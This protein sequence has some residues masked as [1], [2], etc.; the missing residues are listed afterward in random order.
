[1]STDPHAELLAWAY[2]SRVVEGPSRALQSLLEA[3]WNA[4]DIA[5]GVHTRDPAVGGLIRETAARHRECHPEADLEAA[6]A[7]GARLIH[8]GHPDWPAAELDAAFGFAG[9]QAGGRADAVAPHALW[10]RGGSPAALC[11]Q[12][13]ALVGTRAI[14]RYGAEVTGSLAR[15]L[16]GHRW[17]VVS[18][19]ALGVDAVA[20]TACL[21]AG[22]STVVVAAC[23]I[24]VDYPR[25]HAR[26]F[27]RVTE[28][29]A[30]VSEYPP[31]ATPHRHRFLTRNRLVAALSLGTVVTEA[32]WRSGALNTLSWA[33][34][35]GRVCMAVPGPVTTAG[36]VGCHERIRT[37]TAE[38]VTSADDVRALVGP[39]GTPDS[40][41]Q[42]ELDFGPDPVQRLDR[43]QL[44]VFDALEPGEGRTAGEV[45]ATAGLPLPLTVH[46]LVGLM[47]AGLVRLE[48]ELWHRGQLP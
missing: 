4:R 26:L 13:V 12:A 18:G 41:E 5:A 19:G 37:R 45:A 10:V 11:A 42:Y 1:M 3:G 25:R 15:G 35:L 34:H 38:L 8:P 24:D 48:G 33:E 9:Q 29:G 31:G 21:D 16:A 46:L 44:R 27:D 6:A 28:H 2:L 40:G 7:V 17:T 22:G 14:S 32:A 20:H 23:G 47:R 36:S 30:V 39:A 43:N